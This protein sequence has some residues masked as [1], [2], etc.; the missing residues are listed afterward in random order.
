MRALILGGGGITGIA[1]E[2]GLLAGLRRQG[3]GLDGADLI[4]GTSAGSYVGALLATGADLDRAVARTADID[5]ELSPRIDPALLAQGFAV[6]S[7][8][9]L[10]PVEK[11]RLL[12][13]LAVRAPLGD[14]TPHVARFAE[15]LPEHRWP[16]HPRL[17]ITA[18]DTATGELTAWDAAAGVPLPA[19]VAASCALPGVFPP[20]RVDGSRFMD[21][22]VR[23][24]TNTDLAAG[25]DAVIVVA[26]TSNMF[27][28]TPAEELDRLNPPRRLLIAPDPAAR[29]A[30]GDNILNPSRRAAALA[31]GGAQAESVAAAVRD[32]WPG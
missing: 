16:E 10:A 31:A 7:D 8:S 13:Q 15:T 29:A 5:V 1:W 3:A 22:G 27:R 28:A 23:S 6:L 20:V 32:V 24:V 12:G 21:G 11:R 9:S 4:V 30:I 25:A 18:I 26:P 2:L 14:D 17:V 19:A